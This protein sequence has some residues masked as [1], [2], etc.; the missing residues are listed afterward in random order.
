MVWAPCTW[1]SAPS[2]FRPV[3]HQHQ[4]GGL[5]DHREE[6]GEH[7]LADLVD[8]V[9]ILDD[10]DRRCFP[11]QGGGVDQ[12]GQPPP[13]GIRIDL[14]QL[15][16]GVG[17]AQQVLEQQ[18]VLGVGVGILGPDCARA[19]GPSRPRT[20]VASRSSRATAWKGTWVVW[21]SQ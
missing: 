15:D 9:R 16:V 19:A 11:G 14:G 21:D 18:Q 6:V 12:S 1:L 2:I 13:P 5:R 20:P 7:R 10:V 4:R 17:D 3:G 8:P